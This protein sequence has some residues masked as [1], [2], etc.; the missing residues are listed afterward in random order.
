MLCCF[1]YQPFIWPQKKVLFFKKKMGGAPERWLGCWEYRLHLQRTW[2]W[3]S[4]QLSVRDLM[5]SFGLHGHL[6]VH[7]RVHTH[8]S[9]CIVI[10]VYVYVSVDVS[11]KW[12]A[13]PLKVMFQVV[14]CRLLTMC[15]ESRIKCGSCGWTA[16]IFSHWLCH[17]PSSYYFSNFYLAHPFTLISSSTKKKN[18]K[19]T[20]RKDIWTVIPVT[21]ETETGVSPEVVRSY[22]FPF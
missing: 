1:L 21:Q 4:T 11:Q 19:H 17:L 15:W 6:L 2:L 13:D 7:V 20:L 16:N 3:F 12:T 10:Y 22:F 9:P 8:T 5:P 18:L 14:G